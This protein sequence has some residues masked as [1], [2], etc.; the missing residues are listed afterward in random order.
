M[1][2]A[3]AVLDGERLAR[4][5][6]HR[7]FH[8]VAEILARLLDQHPGLVIVADDEDV[9]ADLHADGISLAKI[10]IDDDAHRILL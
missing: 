1:G 7:R 2:V 9:R 8:L 10:S 6:P 5:P 4:A 3:S